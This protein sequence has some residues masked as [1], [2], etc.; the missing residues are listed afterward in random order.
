VSLTTLEQ[1]PWGPD[2]HVYDGGLVTSSDRAGDLAA[3]VDART[4]ET[5]RKLVQEPGWNKLLAELLFTLFPFEDMPEAM[6]PYLKKVDDV[7][8][9]AFGSKYPF[10]LSSVQMLP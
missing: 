7:F 9:R 3:T 1:G 4:V 8:L 10:L 2:L 6:R 5:M